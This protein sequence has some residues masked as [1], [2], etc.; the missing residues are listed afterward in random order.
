V[1]ADAAL[2]GSRHTEREVAGHQAEQEVVQAAAELVVH[3]D[4]PARHGL[5]VGGRVAHGAVRGRGVHLRATLGI[6]VLLLL[7][8]ALGVL[9]LLL[10]LLGVTLRVLILLLLLGVTLRVLILLLLMVALGRLILLL[11][12]RILLLGLVRGISLRGRT[13]RLRLTV[14]RRILRGRTL[15]RRRAVLLIVALRRRMW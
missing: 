7:G 15:L 3:D 8:A 12:L 6:L 1:D 10:L 2:V 4:P 13:I 11:L 5:R 14:G 9:I